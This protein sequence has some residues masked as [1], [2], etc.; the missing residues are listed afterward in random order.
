MLERFQRGTV[1]RVKKQNYEVQ[2]IDEDIDR[3]TIML[4]ESLE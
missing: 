4:R 1:I 2:H 3:A